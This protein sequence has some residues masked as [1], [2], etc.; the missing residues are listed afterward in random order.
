MSNNVASLF[1]GPVGTREPNETCVRTLEEWL[2]R[3]RAGEVV[4]VAIAGLCFD[5]TACWSAS[6]TVGGYALVGAMEVAKA[7]VLDVVRG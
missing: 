4:G 6:G 1:G 7:E 3:A 5:H 2:E